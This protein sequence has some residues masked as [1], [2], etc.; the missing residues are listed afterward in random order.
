MGDESQD[1]GNQM[2]LILSGLLAAGLGIKRGIHWQS[3][4][5][6]VERNVA[7]TS[8]AI[9]ILL[10]IGALAGSWMAGGIVPAMMYYG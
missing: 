1:G 10:L 2:I 3:M 4:M 7:T 6:G 5:E 9:I 8:Q